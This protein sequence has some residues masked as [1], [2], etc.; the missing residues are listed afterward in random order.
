MAVTRI[1]KEFRSKILRPRVLI[2]FLAFLLFMFLFVLPNWQ[3]LRGNFFIGLFFLLGSLSYVYRRRFEI[4]IGV[5]FI[6]I[7][8]LLCTLAY[9]LPVGFFLGNTTTFLAELIGSKVDERIIINLLS[10][11]AMILSIPLLSGLATVNLL[12]VAVIANLVY[13]VIGVFGNLFFGGNPGKTIIFVSTNV[14]W[15]FAFFLNIGPIIY[16]NFMV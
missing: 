5:E 4:R 3:D 9:G 2:P 8:T 15:T 11:N 10:I 7:G 12:L 16:Y 1:T 13:N 14:I 6:S